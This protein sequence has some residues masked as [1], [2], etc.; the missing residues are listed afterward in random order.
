MLP[1]LSIDTGTNYDSN[2][3][4]VNNRW[5]STGLNLSWNLMKLVSLPSQI[6]ANES[7]AR[8]DETRRLAMT[9]AVLGQT[10]I[11]ALR[12]RLL[13]QEFAIWDDAV[14]DDGRIVGMTAS[15]SNF[16]HSTG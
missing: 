16:P 7:A 10:R 3:Y 14:N 9:A 8:I 11:A 12:Y 5:A 13:T 1:S 15:F 4:L 6:R 2:K